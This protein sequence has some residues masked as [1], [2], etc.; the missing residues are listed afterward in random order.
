MDNEREITVCFTGPRP[1]NPYLGGYDWSTQKNQNFITM[2]QKIVIKLVTSPKYSRVNFICG[3]ALGIDQMAFAICYALKQTKNYP[4]F[5]TITLAAPY[6]DFYTHWISETDKERHARHKEKADNYIE[7]DTIPEYQRP[8][9]TVNVYS[10]DKLQLR[11]IYMVDHSDLVIATWDG[12][13]TNGKGKPSGTYNCVTTVKQQNKP[14]IIL[15]PIDYSV[16]FDYHGS[17][18][19]LDVN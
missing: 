11:N 3:G 16:T 14:L 6:Q 18:V 7:V 2:L 10:A 8:H 1:D 15:N 5:G 12:S 17:Q 19:P 13:T 9:H 4:K